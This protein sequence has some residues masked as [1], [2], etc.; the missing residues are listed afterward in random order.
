MAEFSESGKHCSEQY[1][2]QLDFLPFT[3]QYC[4]RVFCLE[5]FKPDDHNC[6]NPQQ[7]DNDRRVVLCPICNVSIRIFPGQ[8]ETVVW[9]S[10][11]K[12]GSCKPVA[13]G[14]SGAPK[15]K[16]CPVAG[17]RE[18]LTFVNSFDCKN[19]SQTVCM[20]H[21]LEM[22]H[23]CIPPGKKKG[24]NASGALQKSKMPGQP[25]KSIMDMLRG[26]FGV[27]KKSKKNRQRS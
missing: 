3:C 16:R 26:L 25:K 12:S 14:P 11:N 23:M 19:C 8:S 9:E 22:D 1:C 24:G 21:R 20:K 17:C 2:R 18:Q 7:I 4:L 10:H 27:S 6:T 5:H 15:K 13:F